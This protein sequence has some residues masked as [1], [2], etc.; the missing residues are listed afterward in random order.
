MLRNCPN[1]EEHGMIATELTEL[2]KDSNIQEADRQ[3]ILRSLREL[4]DTGNQEAKAALA[5]VEPHTS[6]ITNR[7]LVDMDTVAAIAHFQ[8][9]QRALYGKY[10]AEGL[11][12]PECVARLRENGGI[13][14]NYGLIESDAQ[15]CEKADKSALFRYHLLTLYG[16]LKSA[17]DYDWPA[18]ELGETTLAKYLPYEWLTR[19]LFE[20]MADLELHIKLNLG[21]NS[22]EQSLKSHPCIDRVREIKAKVPGSYAWIPDAVNNVVYSMM[23]G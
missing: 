19:D 14:L 15:T 17:P 23:H 12:G 21:G 1:S 13:A 16:H 11:T 4:A 6:G 3:T 7:N 18:R 9:R 2:L 20:A 8:A 22:L 10:K 5:S